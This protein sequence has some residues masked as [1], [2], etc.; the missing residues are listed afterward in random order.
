[1]HGPGLDYLELVFLTLLIAVAVLALVAKRLH[2]AYPIMLV[3]GGLVLSLIPH[4]PRVTMNP[5]VVFLVILPP[6][7]FSAAFHTS[8]RDFR[9]NLTGIVM[10]AFGL[11]G[12]TIFGVAG[13]MHFLIPG[14]DW[15]LGLVLGSLIAATDAIAATATAKRLG[16]PRRI[17]DLLEAESLVND[18]SGLVAL[19]FTLAMVVTSITP[20][21]VVGAATLF[22]LVFGAV[23]VGL[24]AG[25]IVH[26]IQEQI[27]DAPVEIT[28]SLVTPYIAYLAAERL[29]CSGV[30]AT[31]ACGLYLGR[32]SSGFY[33]LHA[34][35][36]SSA[37]WRTLDFILNGLVFLVLGLQL[38]YILADIKGVSTTSII[39]DGAIFSL[40]VIVLRFLWL[41]P[42]EW[43]SRRLQQM[44]GRKVRKTKTGELFLVGWAGMRGVLALAAALSLPERLGNGTP[45]PFRN[46]IIFLT[47]C[48]IFATLVMQGLSMPVLIRMLGLGSSAIGFEEESTARRQ[49]ISAALRALG[50]IRKD[51]TEDQ[52]ELFDHLESYYRHR[53]ALL[54]K[55]HDGNFQSAELENLERQRYV[56]QELRNVEREVAI[57]L[58]NENKIHD[59]V[60]R[61]LEH[62]LD[63]LDA[64][65]AE[66]G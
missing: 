46:V 4:I 37:V 35:I 64:R 66:S 3:L 9:T 13:T 8:W 58:R 21:V 32:R 65:Y 11:V 27:D 18:G 52:K 33:S 25:V 57:K 14:F 16:L 60:L 55:D 47:F 12:F 28:I 26:R 44:L 48:V 62:E 10:L 17:T 41:Y 19:K 43:I 51:G 39:L 29:Q 31:L 54:E 34:R 23:V 40:I 56:A 53:M 38:P 1:M 24:I 7:V 50:K 5:S 42:A 45:F 6:L 22:Y 20:S 30:L 15:K 49:M 2:V 61:Q 59:E 63:L 36:E